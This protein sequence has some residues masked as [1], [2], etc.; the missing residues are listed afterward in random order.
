MAAGYMALYNIVFVMLGAVYVHPIHQCP[1]NDSFID[2]SHSFI[3]L[4]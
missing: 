4:S 3:H 2:Q 1:C